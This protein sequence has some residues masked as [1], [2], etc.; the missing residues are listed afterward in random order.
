MA[1]IERQDESASTE[2]RL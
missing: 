2:E 1:P